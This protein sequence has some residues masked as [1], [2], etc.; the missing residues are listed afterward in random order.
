MDAVGHDG[1]RA[2]FLINRARKF[3]VVILGNGGGK[4]ESYSCLLELIGEFL[5]VNVKKGLV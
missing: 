4:T 1:F 5:L 2:L 3:S